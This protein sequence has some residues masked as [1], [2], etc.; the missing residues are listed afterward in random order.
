M[1]TETFAR[2]I[3]L[4]IY[5]LAYITSEEVHSKREFN[6]EY[7]LPDNLIPVVYDL[8]LTFAS[9]SDEIIGQVY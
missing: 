9:N 3:A 1:R 8:K 2:C 7:R 5:H 6:H 4:L